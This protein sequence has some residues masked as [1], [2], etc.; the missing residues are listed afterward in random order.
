ML[1]RLIRA[2]EEH[3][4]DAEGR[5][6]KGTARA[7]REFGVLAL[8]ALPI[9]GVFVPNDDQISV[10]VDRVAAEHLGLE[11]ARSDFREAMAK[12]ENFDR[13]DAIESAHNQIRSVSEEAYFYTGLAFG[14]TIASAL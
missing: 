7:L 8:W 3:G 10:V 5:D 4:R 14:I 11:E 1:A 13:R 6:I 12:V 2:V 9:C